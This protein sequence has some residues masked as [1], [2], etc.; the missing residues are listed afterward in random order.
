MSLMDEHIPP[1]ELPTYE[2]MH[3]AMI[4]FV[5]D[6][7]VAIAAWYNGQLHQHATGTL[8]QFSDRHFL[9]T[10]A[11]A[12]E[13]F[14]KAKSIF[15]DIQLL[16][17][18]GNAN[19][20]VP[21]YGN[22]QATEFARDSTR[23]SVRLRGE[24][25]DFWDIG[26]WE[27]D[28]L[29]VGGLTNKRFLNRSSISLNANLTD[30]VFLLAGYPCS[31]ASADVEAKSA[32]WKWMRY[33]SHPFPDTV[34]LP[35]FD[36]RFHM[37]LFKGSENPQLPDNLVG[38]SG[39]SIWRLSDVPVK[40]SWDVSE[41]RIVAVQTCVYHQAIRGT[42]WQC[43]VPVLTNMVPEIEEAFKKLWLPA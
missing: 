33:I 24:R 5:R 20:L 7:S 21:L 25:D 13:D 9:V 28:Q 10:A 27:L 16:I 17:D 3:E 8:I 38:I 15:P 29:T 42:K 14:D 2:R 22:Y 40:E 23:P 6:H 35:N 18:N 12:I 30:G 39:C 43:V 32:Y 1:E 41:A 19:D 36:E 11:H 26:L 31:W 37:A 4:P 34:E